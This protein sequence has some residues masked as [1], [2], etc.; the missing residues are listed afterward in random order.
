MIWV[1]F[2]G[3]SV[4]VGDSREYRTLLSIKYFCPQAI[5]LNASPAKT[6]WGI[7]LFPNFQNCACCE[8]YLKDNKHDSLN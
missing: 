6:Q 1:Y 7:W 3:V 2:L 8:K 4:A 5:G